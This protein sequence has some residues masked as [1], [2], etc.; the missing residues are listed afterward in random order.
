MAIS[1][2]KHDRE[3]IVAVLL[4]YERKMQVE[5][6]QR[7]KADARANYKE[8]FKNMD[9]IP[10]KDGIRKVHQ[11]YFGPEP[12]QQPQ[13][14][15][16]IMDPANLRRTSTESNAYQLA[17]I[18]QNRD[19]V[20]LKE[21]IADLYK[22][23]DSAQWFSVAFRL[24]ETSVNSEL[25]RT[26]RYDMNIPHDTV[27]N[28]PSRFAGVS[29]DEIY[30]STKWKGHGV[31]FSVFFMLNEAGVQ[32]YID[33]LENLAFGV[34]LA[35]KI[36]LYFGLNALP[37]PQIEYLT[38]KYGDDHLK[39]NKEI[40]EKSVK[41]WN[42]IRRDKH[43]LEDHQ[44]NANKLEKDWG[45]ETD[46][47]IIGETT[48]T[49]LTL[50]RCENTDNWISGQY[51]ASS[52]GAKNKVDSLSDILQVGQGKN[53][54]PVAI[55]SDIK[56]S[57]TDQWNPL[58]SIEIIGQ[59]IMLDNMPLI[60]D[61]DPYRF[62]YKLRTVTCWDEYQKRLKTLT[63]KHFMD[64]CDIFRDSK[65]DGEGEL[66]DV[67][68]LVFDPR[69]LATDSS[70]HSKYLKHDQFL[71]E[72][73]SKANKKLLWKRLEKIRFFGN[74]KNSNLLG[75]TTKDFVYLAKT[76]HKN[77]LS[78]L[79]MTVSEETKLVSDAKI[80]INKI[81]NAKPVA[82]NL[83]FTGAVNK[84]GGQYQDDLN[85]KD[86]AVDP[87]VQVK[88]A[89]L[90]Q[91]NGLRDASQ[92]NSLT[93]NYYAYDPKTMINKYPYL[94][95][96]YAGLREWANT[97]IVGEL[98][99]YVDEKA[100]LRKFFN[101]CDKVVNVLQPSLRT[102]LFLE[103]GYTSTNC[104]QDD[105]TE[106]LVKNT[107]LPAEWYMF[108]V[109]GDA[110]KFNRIK[111]KR[112]D[113]S[114]ATAIASV[115]AAIEATA[116]YPV[117]GNKAAKDKWIK[118][119]GYETLLALFGLVATVANNGTL[120]IASGAIAA[121][122]F[123]PNDLVNSLTKVIPT[124]ILSGNQNKAAYEKIQKGASD[125]V[126]GSQTS[127]LFTIGQLLGEEEIEVSTVIDL[128][129]NG[130]S[131]TQLNVLPA[132][133]KAN[134]VANQTLGITPANNK[135]SVDKLV[136]IWND[137]KT[138]IGVDVPFSHAFEKL[139]PDSTSSEHV[140][141]NKTITK[142]QFLNY[143]EA[144]QNE[145]EAKITLIPSSIKNPYVP[146]AKSELAEM[147]EAL[148]NNSSSNL[149]SGFPTFLYNS[150]Q[151][152]DSIQ[153]KR[154]LDVDDIGLLQYIRNNSRKWVPNESEAKIDERLNHF[155]NKGA[156]LT[157]K[158]VADYID[159]NMRSH[160]SNLHKHIHDNDSMVGPIALVYLFTKYT[161]KVSDAMYENEIDQP[162][163]FIGVRPNMYY[164]VENM[165]RIKAGGTMS[166]KIGDRVITT[167]TGPLGQ[168]HVVNSKMRMGAWK[169][170]VK[171][172]Y[173]VHG[174]CVLEPTMG[175]GTD[176][177][178]PWM[179]RKHGKKYLDFD[180]ERYGESRESIFS[181]A[182]PL[183]TTLETL[184]AV[185]DL[186][187][188]WLTQNPTREIYDEYQ[189]DEQSDMIPPS[190]PNFH[191]YKA[192]WNFPSTNIADQRTQEISVADTQTVQLANTVCHAAPCFY[193]GIGANGLV[194]PTKYAQHGTGHWKVIFQNCHRYRFG[195][196][197]TNVDSLYFSKCEPK[198]C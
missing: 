171:N 114:L 109:V 49:F 90:P 72:V 83:K 185:F 126:F 158:D 9:G 41:H 188:R 48:N 82:K 151:R 147:Y 102:S 52:T 105:A 133:I 59:T 157:S 77:V 131:A 177:Y 193:P 54:T 40:I 63:F 35:T 176:F 116:D 123:A 42:S 164:E 85:K 97:D 189:Y 134:V 129:K 107:L 74:M 119:S 112:L 135:L 22:R 195:N 56:L 69:N 191:R 120:T 137:L 70:V 142:Q 12:T 78:S 30:N 53:G 61:Q 161:K 197:T 128:I 127:L 99:R 68:D 101:M 55:Q 162:I 44:K 124:L 149:S 196:R 150:L 51:I 79:N 95:C 18:Y 192:L 140:R 10:D 34:L 24:E 139:G 29:Y 106:V 194:N 170:N 96:N 81:A 190:Y 152:L 80:I 111:F 57:K 163:S 17:P 169:I 91:D 174:A 141:T 2:E 75:T 86:T 187:G 104:H 19:I 73:A 37:D 43:S 132:Y 155:Y 6:K 45:G 156:A 36:E 100:T 67:A 31:R 125:A 25:R 143:Y 27:P 183:R 145:D 32:L 138:D 89:I 65:E 165:K 178:K 117:T 186:G 87:R 144:I 118:D 58:H 1:S 26:M 16:E 14:A 33:A 159:E 94:S 15:K 182:V 39:V 92:A 38:K 7:L 60:G 122:N 110:S 154:P 168:F 121:A 146:A 23:E 28:T 148:K 8:I 173:L 20:F 136:E 160:V 64:H 108:A 172:L 98:K 47:W 103:K 84:L 66:R 13:V 11:K 50:H 166:R 3:N 130:L 4:Q 167:G 93:G 113:T 5:I 181:M 46:W 198:V 21:R 175:G 180:V 71:M 115:K 62:T 153:Q 179:Q 184:P 76:A 88:R